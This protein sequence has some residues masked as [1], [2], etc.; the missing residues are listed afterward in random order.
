MCYMRRAIRCAIHLEYQHDRLILSHG[1]RASCFPR[2]VIYKKLPIL[3]PT[4]FPRSSHLLY[5][6]SAS[7][8]VSVPISSS[9]HARQSSEQPDDLDLDSL[10]N[11]ED[12]F[13][14]SGHAQG[15]QDGLRQSR[16]ES[17][18]FG[19][20]QGFQKGIVIGRL[21]ARA[22]LWSARLGVPQEKEIHTDAAAED[23]QKTLPPLKAQERLQKTLEKHVERLLAYV[24]PSTLSPANTDDDVAEFDD[25][26]KKALAKV[27]VIERMIGENEDNHLDTNSGK[28]AMKMTDF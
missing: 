1:A 4:S 25:R 6:M 23:A 22:K 3:S 19:V 12:D 11:L 17:R 7:V 15:L 27:K 18:V 5:T 2:I 20:E 24:D 16:F 9:S 8:P 21:Q 28:P 26:L 10:L 14:T 13:Y